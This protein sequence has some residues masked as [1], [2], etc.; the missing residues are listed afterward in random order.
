M[1]GRKRGIDSGRGIFPGHIQKVDLWMQIRKYR[2]KK[3]L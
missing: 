3:N 2:V 1:N